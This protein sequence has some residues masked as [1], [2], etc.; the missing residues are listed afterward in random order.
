[1]KLSAAYRIS[2]KSI[3]FKE[4]HK[5][6]WEKISYKDSSDVEEIDDKN[7]QMVKENNKRFKEYQKKHVKLK[8]TIIDSKEYKKKS[9]RIEKKIYE[10]LKLSI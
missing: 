8:Y 9:C 5:I 3:H 7:K 1:M 4:Y 6:F 2:N 10:K